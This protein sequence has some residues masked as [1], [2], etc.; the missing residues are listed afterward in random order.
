MAIDTRTEAERAYDA[1]KDGSAYAKPQPASDA[2]ARVWEM[3]GDIIADP[4]ND[5]RLHED[6]PLTEEAAAILKLLIRAQEGDAD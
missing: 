2:S 4:M 3:I 1:L 6:E 5:G